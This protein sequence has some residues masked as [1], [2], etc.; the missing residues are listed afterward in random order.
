MIRFN[1]VTWYSK[2]AA[3]I[4]ILGVVPAL[5]FFIGARYQEVRD[6]AAETPRAPAPAEPPAVSVAEIRYEMREI[7]GVSVPQ[8]VGYPDSATMKAVNDQLA[9]RAYGYRC[10]I[11]AGPEALAGAVPGYFDARAQVSHAADDVF[12]VHIR[13]DT[14]CGGPYPSVWDDSVTFD[15]RTGREMRLADIF[16]RYLRDR[17][18]IASAVFAGQIQK[19]GGAPDGQSCNGL[20]SLDCEGD[21]LDFTESLA[22][23][24]DGGDLVMEPS[25]PHA[26]AVCAEEG[27][28]PA[29][30]LSRFFGPSSILARVR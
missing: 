19:Y 26:V 27:R 24:I 9:A 30:R 22:Y 10:D 28:V 17:K 13:V 18:E 8:V 16:D 25:F 14:Y 2:L 15:M 4:V 5:A 23:R 11:A 20:Y 21:C 1:E 7:G 6:L 3:A 29:E 12:S